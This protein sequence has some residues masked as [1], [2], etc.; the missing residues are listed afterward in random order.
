MLRAYSSAAE[1]PAHNWLVAGSNPAGPT[2]HQGRS[3]AAPFLFGRRR[4]LMDF[5]DRARIII[6]AGNGGN[7]AAHFRREKFAPFGGPDG[8]DG[9]RGGSIYLEADPNL[10]TLV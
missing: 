10:N 3:M 5:F 1:R 6:K 2:T 7:G 9:G 8:G 4:E